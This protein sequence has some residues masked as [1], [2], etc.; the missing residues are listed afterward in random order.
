M[1]AVRSNFMSLPLI[2]S[3]YS[4]R[5]D[6]ARSCSGFSRSGI[7]ALKNPHSHRKVTISEMQVALDQVLL[8]SQLLRIIDTRRP[9]K[10]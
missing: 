10:A 3:P 9:K 7:G 8:A 1:V 2:F 6:A 4:V 5:L